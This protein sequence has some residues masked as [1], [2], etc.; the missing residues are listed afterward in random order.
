M[1][2]KLISFLLTRRKLSER[3]KGKPIFDAPF[4]ARAHGRTLAARL[5]FAHKP[6]CNDVEP[7]A[8]CA[9]APRPAENAATC[10]TRSADGRRSGRA[11]SPVPHSEERRS[12]KR[13]GRADRPRAVDGEIA[14][15]A[16]WPARRRWP[17]PAH[18]AALRI[19]AS[20]LV[21]EAFVL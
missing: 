18:S 9:A 4:A 12:R 7:P 6:I 3:R 14:D 2:S 8:R 11:A 17:R 19:A 15:A 1:E 16:D 5:A 20:A 13:L 21:L 10:R